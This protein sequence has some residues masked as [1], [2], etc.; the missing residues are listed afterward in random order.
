[1]QQGVGSGGRGVTATG[2]EPPGTVPRERIA[3][4]SKEVLNRPELAYERTE[5]IVRVHSLGMDWDLGTV[6]Y[7]PADDGDARIGADGRRVG[8]LLLHGGSGDFKHME[9]LSRLLVSRFGYT[10]LAATLPGRF[11]LPDLS[12]DWPG[13]TINPD[14]TV[15]TPVWL[16]GEEIDPSQYTVV[17]DTSLRDRY[18]TRTLARAEP[19]TTFFHRMAAWTAAFEE[20]MLEAAR[21]HLPEDTY[22]V[23]GEGHST[24]GPFICMLSQRIPNMVGVVAT[25]HSPF[26]YICAMRDDWGGHVGKIA[27]Q[28]KIEEHPEPRRDPFNELYIRT[29]RDIARYSGPEA[30]GRE[31]AAALMK[32]PALMEDVLEAW[33]QSLRRPQFKAEY[34]IT[35]AIIPSLVEAAK[36]TATRLGLDD[37]AEQEL[38]D[39]FVGYTRELSGPDVKPVPPF[40]FCISAH[41]RDHSPEVY[42][43]VIMPAFRAMEPAP[44]V[45]LVRF[46]A[47]GHTFWAADEGLPLG[48]APAVVQVWDDAIAGGYFL[49]GR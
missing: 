12:R 22:S 6:V 47:G 16:R 48:I 8:I 23:Y 3:A 7:R 17:Q 45:D 31:G 37:L 25:E 35:H 38:I 15:R 42:E 4:L 41:S 20:G 2:W 26:G 1:M 28:E 44:R 18:G 39:R 11:Y 9:P 32:L 30:L 29:W 13:D 40:L 46:G 14:G 24:G 21:R 5:D 27:G 36:V 10:V 34:V 33:S 43:E 19:G 49:T